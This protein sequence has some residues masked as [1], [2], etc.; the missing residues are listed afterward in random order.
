[1]RRI[2]TVVSV[3]ML[4]VLLLATPGLVAAK[5][6][7]GGG[8]HGGTWFNISGTISDLDADAGTID[9]GDITVYTTDDTHFRECD[10]GVSGGIKFDDLELG[11]SVRIRGV[12]D[13]ATYYASVVIQYVP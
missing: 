2:L 3:G 1:M 6:G 9:V 11:W 12:V 5:G 7:H 4:F 13:G 10:D 8:G